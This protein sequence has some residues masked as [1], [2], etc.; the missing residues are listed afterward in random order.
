M[1]TPEQNSKQQQVRFA[2]DRLTRIVESARLGTWEWNIET[3]ELEWSRE[4]LDM[5]GLPH[6]TKMSYDRFLE[7]LVP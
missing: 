4:C 2:D 7:A 3:G 1:S 5:F 6:D